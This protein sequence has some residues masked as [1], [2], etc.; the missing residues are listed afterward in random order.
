MASIMKAKASMPCVWIGDASVRTRVGPGPRTDRAAARGTHPEEEGH[1][2]E[3][4]VCHGKIN[5]RAEVR[6]VCGVHLIIVL[7]DKQ[8]RDE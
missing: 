8:G 1:G 7:I 4:E 6:V 2:E 3:E 5:D